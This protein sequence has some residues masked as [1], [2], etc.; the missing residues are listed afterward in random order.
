MIQPPLL[1]ADPGRRHIHGCK[2]HSGILASR[3]G[4]H[5]LRIRDSQLVLARRADTSSSTAGD[6]RI[7]FEAPR[8]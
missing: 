3:C 8:A 2:R 6:E 7:Q 4:V 1:L 5:G